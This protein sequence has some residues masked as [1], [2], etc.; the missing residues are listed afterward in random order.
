MKWTTLG[1]HRLIRPIG[2]GGM[3]EVFLAEDSKLGRQVAIKILPEHLAS[4]ASRRERFELEARAVASLNHPNIVTIHSVEHAEGVHFLTME[5]VDGKPLAEMIPARGLPIDEFLRIAIP[6]ADAV[7]AAHQKGIVHRDLKPANVVLTSD[8]RVK[9]LD[10]GLA[11]LRDE[12]PGDMAN[13]PTRELTGEGRIVG[14]VA[15]MSPEQAAGKLVDHRSDV[16]SLGVV[17]YQ[18]LTGEQPFTGDTGVAIISSVLKDT[19]RSVT[20]VN[21]ALPRPLGHIIKTCLQKDPE[22]RYQSAKDLRNE[23]QSLKEDLGSGELA[24]AGD[25]PVLHDRP[26]RFG[27][28]TIGVGLLALAAVGY[29]AVVMLRPPPAP[30]LAIGGHTQLTSEPGQESHPSISPDGKWIVYDALTSGNAD[31]YL[32]SV[33][34][35]TA[36][37]LTKDSPASDVQPAFSPDGEH[38]AFRSGRDGGGIFIMG[39]TG[40]APRRVTDRGF[41]PAW[42]PDGKEIVFSTVVAAL[43]SGRQGIGELWIADVG[44]GKT[45]R[46]WEGDG[47]D[48]AWSP[49]GRFVAYWGMSIGA[50]DPRRWRDIW[51]IPAAGGT[52]IQITH[53]APVDW[54]PVWSRDGRWL[55]FASDRG[56]SMNL[57]RVGIDP[58]SGQKRGEPEP[59]TTPSPYVAGIS[60]SADGH[61]LVYSSIASHSNVYR[62]GFDPVTATVTGEMT[63]VTSGSRAWVWAV[64]SPDGQRLALAKGFTEREDLFISKADGSELRQLTD[65]DFYDRCPMWSPNGTRIAFYSNRSGKYE[66]WTIAPDG[67]TLQPMTNAPEYSALYPSW[68]PNG[69]RMA[70]VDL[71]IKHAVV[72]FDP[73]K[74]WS[75]QKPEVLPPPPGPPNSN[76]VGIAW[77]ADGRHLAGNVNGGAGGV[78]VFNFDTRTYDRL[79]ETASG[80]NLMQWLPDGRLLYS[81][82]GVLWLADPKAHQTKPL[83]KVPAPEGLTEPQYTAE[84]RMLYFIRG[85]READIWMVEIK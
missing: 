16:F 13:M 30:S 78:Q 49:N 19:P 56:G 28:V 27:P 71:T 46:L 45:R 34:G 72:V 60:L 70:F 3:G 62:V 75:E 12:Q 20:D 25:V 50:N 11:K 5:F 80:A 35:Q 10:F 23:L 82:G 8:G 32:R 84:G 15:Y 48:P 36:I 58:A 1:H 33:G 31:I 14:T 53:D 85:S 69:E 47:L 9:V 39:R 52:P 83:L 6:L 44:S 41:S 38:I 55:Y 40:E 64:P 21:R 54:N 65:D 42:S 29:V 74:S 37:N 59:V 67:G 76:F 81:S 22:R 4:D 57:W 66:I 61:R 68:S 77:S 63:P 17:M 26:S 73:R 43:P 18:M 51:T 79:V 7:G 24:A 2:E